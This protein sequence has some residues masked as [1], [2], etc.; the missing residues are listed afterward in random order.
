MQ[1]ETEERRLK[2]VKR[3][4]FNAI[5]DS[6]QRHSKVPSEIFVSFRDYILLKS[7]GQL[8]ELDHYSGSDIKVTA[9]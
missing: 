2:R 1:D 8:D 9:G 7:V 3:R 6:R 5:V 4:V